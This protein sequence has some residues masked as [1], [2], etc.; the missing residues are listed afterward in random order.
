MH[1]HTWCSVNHEVC[2]VQLG[3]DGLFFARAD[4]DDIK[5]RREEKS[6]EM[7]WRASKSLGKSAEVG[8]QPAPSSLTEH[9]H[10]LP[11]EILI[12]LATVRD[13]LIFGL[14]NKSRPEHLTQH[15]SCRHLRAS[16]GTTTI[17]PTASTST[18]GRKT[19]PS[20]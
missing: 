11:F 5:K 15:V 19:R 17:P 13:S 8:R 2:W 18:S 12:A 3:F 10:K 9:R 6:M 16:W 7:V 1:N 20:R 14:R 4:Y